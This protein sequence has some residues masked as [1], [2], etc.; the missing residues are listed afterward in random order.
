MRSCRTELSSHRSSTL[1]V[2]RPLP[3]ATPMAPPPPP[4]PPPP[5]CLPFFGGSKKPK[6]LEYGDREH[7]ETNVSRRSSL[8]RLQHSPSSST[9]ATGAS[10]SEKFSTDSE[11]YDLTNYRNE[12]IEIRPGLGRSETMK[13]KGNARV[14][15]PIDE[16]GGSKKWKNGY[17]WGI[18]KKNKEKEME[19]EREGADLSR[20]NT[21]TSR[22]PPVYESP[23]PTRRNS[24]RSTSSSS[25][26]GLTV[27][28]SIPPHM[29][30]RASHDSP[31]RSNSQRTQSS[32]RTQGSSRRAGLQ[33][34]DS[35]S[36][37]VGSI[38]DRKMNDSGSSK[39]RPDSAER[40]EALRELMK[41]DTLDY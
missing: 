27:A 7:T 1:G 3:P 16:K 9:I 35:A 14:L 21:Q 37:L 23:R 8:S 31:T 33:A 36:T 34:S 18:G 38:L 28:T 29:R 13:E 24:D 19:R 4:P 22:P 5:M 15:P 40:L 39:D 30:Q 26:S 2:Y 17:G 25:S 32:G 10:H 12:A 20:N 11:S 6:R 41:K